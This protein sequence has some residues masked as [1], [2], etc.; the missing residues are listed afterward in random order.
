MM[1]IPAPLVYFFEHFWA[2]TG[3]KLNFFEI[4]FLAIIHARYPPQ[5]K[6]Y[7]YL[8][9][10]PTNT[11]KT[12]QL[13]LIVPASSMGNVLILSEKKGPFSGSNSHLDFWQIFGGASF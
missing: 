8:H 13:S 5:Y 2:S 3:C 7:V 12:Q 9:V 10:Y 1:H 4:L 11:C 6:L